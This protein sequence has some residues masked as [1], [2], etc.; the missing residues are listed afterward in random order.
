MKLIKL[1]LVIEALSQ[2]TGED[3]ESTIK[4]LLHARFNG[5][6]VHCCGNGGSGSTASHFSADLQNLGFDSVCLNDSLPRVSALTNDKGWGRVYTE[7]LSQVIPEDVLVLFTVHGSEGAE[8]AGPWS[9][10]LVEAYKLCVSKGVYVIVFSGNG[11][12][13]FRNRDDVLLVPVESGDVYVVEGVHSV[14]AHMVCDEL[15]RRIT[16]AKP[17]S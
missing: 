1:P 4:A 15:K 6:R 14:L 11:G 3:Y 12:G 2:V 17:C 9:Q 5:F 10:N 7:Q 16:D 13:Y 8:S